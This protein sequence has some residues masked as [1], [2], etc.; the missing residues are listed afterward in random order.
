MADPERPAGRSAAARAR[1][2][3]LSSC[4]LERDRDHRTPKPVPA[5]H[6]LIASAGAAHAGRGGGAASKPRSLTYAELTARAGALAAHLRAL[7]RG[8]RGAGGDLRRA[9]AGDGR[10]D[11]LAILEAGG[12]YVPLDPSLS[13][14]AAG[15]HAGG[16]ARSPVLAHSE[17]SRGS[18]AGARRAQWC[19][20]TSARCPR[21]PCRPCAVD[22]RTS[23]AYVI[24]T[25]GSTGR[26]K[27]VLNSHRA[28]VNRLLWMQQAYGLGAG[29][30][31]AAEDAR[32]AS[33]SRC[34]SSSGR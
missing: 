21:Q 26:P 25:S 27:G 28:I 6:E 18:P 23:L 9:L 11:S 30:P 12:A 16:R 3:A 19:C 33:T 31:R 15:L 5:S 14:R 22:R 1:P 29:R 32:S 4:S 34:G 17:P 7:G 2:S 13:G 8:A 20:S 24:F 10:G